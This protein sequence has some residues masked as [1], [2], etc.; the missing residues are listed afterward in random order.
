MNRYCPMATVKG[1]KQEKMIVVPRRFWHS[2]SGKFLLGCFVVL[3]GLLLVELGRWQE[4]S[5]SADTR[6]EGS[7]LSNSMQRSSNEVKELQAQLVQAEQVTSI[8]KLAMQDL[9]VNIERLR[10]QISQL[11]EDVLFYKEIADS[12]GG[13]QGLVV[14]QLDLLATD[15]PDHYRYKIKFEQAGSTSDVVE[16]YASIAVAGVKD[17]MELTLPLV[18]LSNSLQG[19]NIRLRFRSFQ[20]VEGELTLPYGFEPSRMEILAVTEEPDSKTLQ[21][22]FGWLVES[23]QQAI[24]R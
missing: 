16:G 11:E 24:P 18:A 15:A 6:A 1:S 13:E 20:D 8:D 12:G 22:N 23:D 3:A 10:Q 2:Q 7:W 9:R 21:K 4:S 14:S 17:D 5:A 19:E